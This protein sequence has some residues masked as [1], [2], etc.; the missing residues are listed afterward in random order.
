[1]PQPAQVTP[2]QPNTVLSEYSRR[3]FEEL[4]ANLSHNSTEF[5]SNLF[6]DSNDYVL[7]NLYKLINI[8]NNDVFNDFLGVVA[9]ARIGTS[10]DL[11]YTELVSVRDILFLPFDKHQVFEQ[12]R[13]RVCFEDNTLFTNMDHIK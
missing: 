2:A 6:R 1:L 4:L 13:L 10:R 5:I 11:I 9:L 7:E 8:D 3:A 12:F